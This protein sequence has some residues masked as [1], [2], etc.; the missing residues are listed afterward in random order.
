[1]GPT[2]GQ[3]YERF[4]EEFNVFSLQFRLCQANQTA[5]VITKHAFSFIT[6]EAIVSSNLLD[7]SRPF[8]RADEPQTFLSVNEYPFVRV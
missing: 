4:R 3:E 2:I 1:M 8:V 5:D 6:Y 7:W